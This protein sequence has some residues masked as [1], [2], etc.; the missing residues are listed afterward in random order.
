VSQD[1]DQSPPSELDSGAEHPPLEEQVIDDEACELSE[2]E[3]QESLEIAK[4]ESDNT[5]VSYKNLG[6][7]YEDTGLAKDT[8]RL[9]LIDVSGS[10]INRYLC[11]GAVRWIPKPLHTRPDFAKIHLVKSF[12]GKE[13]RLVVIDHKDDDCKDL[14]G[15]RQLPD[16]CLI[17]YGGGFH[18]NGSPVRGSAKGSSRPRHIDPLTW[19]SFGPAD[20]AAEGLKYLRQVEN[21]CRRYLNAPTPVIPTLPETPSDPPVVAAVA[22]PQ[23][24]VDHIF[25][26]AMSYYRNMESMYNN[27]QPPIVLELCCSPNSAIGRAGDQLGV[28]VFR[29]HKHNSDIASVRTERHAAELIKK[30]PNATLHVSLPCTAWT[31]ITDT[32]ISQYGQQYSKRLQEDRLKSLESL[33]RVIRLCEMV[34]GRGGHMA[35]EWPVEAYG[36]CVTELKCFIERWGLYNV[37]PHGC[38]YMNVLHPLTPPYTPLQVVFPQGYASMNFARDLINSYGEGRIWPY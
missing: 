18:L 7:L 4:E 33:R 35:F 13:S 10:L 37:F 25:R 27:G 8:L 32:N 5:V 30:H 34:L 26:D 22:S 11:K 6:K 24:E 21:N 19:A 9:E 12:L 29:F 20:R 38:A 36:W 3:V 1:K 15:Y 16:S 17:Q 14:E 23:S 2:T 31:R 28:P